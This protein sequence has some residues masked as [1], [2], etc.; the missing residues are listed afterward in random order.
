MQR[1]IRLQRSAYERYI[2]DVCP[3]R[4]AAAGVAAAPV[5]PALVKSET[6]R[7]FAD[8]WIGYNIFGLS[9]DTPNAYAAERLSVSQQNDAVD[10]AAGRW[11]KVVQ[12][13]VPGGGGREDTKAI[14]QLVAPD[15]NLTILDPGSI[16]KPLWAFPVL[17][18]AAAAQDFFRR[19]SNKWD[20]E[21]WPLSSKLY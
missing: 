15:G 5:S 3:R 12:T 16:R 19:N 11:P 21:Q 13:F 9:D 17:G 14:L 20:A 2:F 18:N 6:D 4:S 7:I 10:F 8:F 1:A